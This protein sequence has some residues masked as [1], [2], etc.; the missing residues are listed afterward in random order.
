VPLGDYRVKE[1]TAPTD[2]APATDVAFALVNS[3]DLAILGF[4]NG[5]SAVAGQAA[6][7]STDAADVARAD[8]TATAATPDVPATPAVPPT[9]AVVVE[10]GAPAPAPIVTT[11]PFGP[12]LLQRIA[13]TPRKVVST[14]LKGL[15]VFL[16]SPRELGLMAAVWVLVWMPCY[17]A[18]RRRL[19]ARL[20][21]SAPGGSS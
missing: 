21:V 2:Y 5:L 16:S 11:T 1:T 15:S 3:G 7:P 6:T 18:E 8:T 13:G 17:L 4:R 10:P 14:A 20:I 9:E 19:A 12:S